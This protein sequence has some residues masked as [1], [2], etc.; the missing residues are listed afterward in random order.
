MPV[1]FDLAGTSAVVTGGSKGIG[2][3]IARHL[4]RAGARV[5]VWDIDPDPSDST[6]S[7]AVDITKP[8]QIA[9]ALAQTLTR[10]PE[11]DVLVND[12]GH[13]GRY[14]PFERLERRTWRRIRL[15][16]QE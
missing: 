15:P 6:G 2:K 10:T 5:W 8:D 1:S 7:I 4:V 3:A 14:A 16:A 13:L 9:T 12:A 11:I